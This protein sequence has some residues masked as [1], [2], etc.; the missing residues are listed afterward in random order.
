MNRE[1]LKEWLGRATLKHSHKKQGRGYNI[2]DTRIYEVDGELFSLQFCNG[3]TSPVFTVGRGYIHGTYEPTPVT[4][5]VTQQMFT[6]TEFTD[7]G[8]NEVSRHEL[9]NS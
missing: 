5:T 7:E 6:V 3:H 8:G 9:E 2:I 1:E 4:E